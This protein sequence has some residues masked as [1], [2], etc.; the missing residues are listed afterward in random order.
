M[1]TSL[2]RRQML[3][4]AGAAVSTTL[5]RSPSSAK[6]ADDSKDSPFGYCL[7]MSTIR[8]QKLSLPEQVDVAAKAGYDA[9][10]PWT[11]EVRQYVDGGGSLKDLKKRISDAGLTVESAIGFATWIVDD[12]ARRIEGYETARRDMELMRD[13]G[14][15]RIAAPP[16]GAT[17]QTDLNLFAAAE[18]YHK[19]LDIGDEI[20]VVA[21]LELWG[22]S[23]SM[24]RLGELAFVATECGHPNACVLPDVY[25]IFKGGSDFEGLKMIEGSKIHVFHMNDYP[26]DP[27]RDKIGDADRV[28]PGDGIAP[29]GKILRTLRDNGSRC[30]LSLELFNRSYWEQ[31]P[32]AVAQTGLTKMRV[33]VAGA[34]SA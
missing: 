14:G 31:D 29:L 26:A 7:N 2:D 9:I 27:P 33:A 28:Y 21:E 10:E 4:A 25:H 24:S 34:L 17:K 20:G 5:L 18:R 16:V 12:D 30:M 8:G 11:R 22:F 3:A 19:L 15:I 23:K 32:L 6:A 13:I 1:S